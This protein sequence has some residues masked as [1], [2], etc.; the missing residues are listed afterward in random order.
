MQEGSLHI[1]Y[2]PKKGWIEAI[3]LKASD[4]LQLLNG[5]YVVV[6]AVQHEI[7]EK[8]VKIYNFEV[9]DFHTYY[10]GQDNS[11]LVHNTYGGTVKYI[12]KTTSEFWKSYNR[13]PKNI[14][15]A[16]DKAFAQFKSNPLHNGLNFEKL[17]GYTNRYS[18]R[19][20]QQYR[21]IGELK[22]NTI[23]WIKITPHNYKF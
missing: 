17:S 12:N 21:A 18:V 7:L 23:K 3:N 6:E 10:V 8:P 14:Q 9:E 20:N 2:S 19:I 4:V 16:A 5:S 13:L 11:V 22:G 1:I 15:K